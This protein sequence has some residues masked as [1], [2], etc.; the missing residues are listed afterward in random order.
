MVDRN[1]RPTYAALR[2]I[3]VISP[4]RCKELFQMRK[5]LQSAGAISGEIK[6]P[7]VID[8]FKMHQSGACVRSACTFGAIHIEA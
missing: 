2:K 7:F 8:G 1:A 4:E 3:F 5:E 6:E